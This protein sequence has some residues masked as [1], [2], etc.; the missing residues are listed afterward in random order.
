MIASAGDSHHV[1]RNA[2]L[3]HERG[4]SFVEYAVLMSVVAVGAILAWQNL[5]ASIERSL[6]GTSQVLDTEEAF[7][8]RTNAA[9]GNAAPPASGEQPPAAFSIGTGHIIDPPGFVPPPEP[10]GFGP[11]V[12]KLI[13]DSPSAT[14]NLLNAKRNGV[15]I[16]WGPAGKGSGFSSVGGRP[17]I[18]MDSSNDPAGCAAIT[19]AAAMQTCIAQKNDYLTQALAHELGHANYTVGYTQS[20]D[21]ATRINENTGYALA[22]E[23]HAEMERLIAEHE[24]T[25]KGG[26]S[27]PPMLPPKEAADMEAIYQRMMSND[28]LK[29]ISR[30]QADAE[31]GGIYSGQHPSVDPTKTYDQYYRDWYTKQEDDAAEAVRLQNEDA[32]YRAQTG[33][34]IGEGPR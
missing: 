9:N 12:D 19:P 34:G 23:G 18:T 28:P 20:T 4:A 24:M 7:T 3:R 16:V 27:F 21:Y 8:A 2:L 29:H 26:H 11:D 32:L 17:T 5:G 13:A 22:G 6:R 1:Q 25:A 33:Y 30:A 31:A 14:A 15:A 10:T